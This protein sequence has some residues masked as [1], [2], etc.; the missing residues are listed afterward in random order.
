MILSATGSGTNKALNVLAGGIDVDA[1]GVSID[2]GGLSIKGS[3]T[4]YTIF[5]G[6]SNGSNITYTLPGTAPT[7]LQILRATSAD[8]TVLE[9]TN[10]AGLLPNSSNDATLRYDSGSSTWLANTNVLS[11][12][13]G[14][15]TLKKTTNQ[16]VLGTTNTTTISAPA[17]S[18]SRTYSIPDAGANASFVMT[19]GTQTIGGDKTLSGMTAINSGANAAAEL[20]FYEP[21]SDG[22]FYTSFKAGGQSANIA[23]T[24]PTTAPTAGQALV[25]DVSGNL[26]WSSVASSGSGVSFDVTAAQAA[27]LGKYVFNLE[28]SGAGTGIAYGGRIS[29]I[30]KGNNSATGLTIS[31]DAAS[32]SNIATGLSIN[33]T[34][35]SAATINYGVNV[36]AGS[37]GA[38]AATGFKAAITGGATTNIG[39]ET[40]ASGGTTSYSAKFGPGSVLIAN[41]GTN[42]TEI[43]FQEPSGSN[44]SAFK[45]QSQT[46]DVTYTLPADAGTNGQMLTTNGSGTL[47]WTSPSG[48][49]ASG[50]TTN[51]TLRYNGSGWVE[52]V[53]VLS[54]SVGA[55]TLTKTTNQL[56]LGTGS[57]TTTLNSVAPAAARTYTIPDAGANAAFVMTAGAQTIADAKTFSTAPILSSLTASKPLKLDGSK[58]VSSGAIDLATAADEVTGT[59]PVANG[60][61]GLASYST[62][63]LVYASTTN[64]LAALATGTNGKVLT[65]SSGVPAWTTLSNQLPTGTTTNAT[66]RYNGSNWVQN[67]NLLAASDGAITITK[68]SNQIVLGS[69]STITISA[70]S[71]LVNRTYTIPDASSN[72][73]FVMTA[74]DQT[75]AGTKTFSTAPN[76]NSLTASKPLKLDGSKNITSGAINLATAGGEVTG[77]LPVANGGTGLTSYA[78]GDLVYASTTNTLAALAKGTDGQYLTLT[79]G[80]PAWGTLSNQLP[81][82]TTT[83][84]TLRYNGS[85]WVQNANV[86]SN[87]DGAL[88]LAK[89][90]NQLT[91]GSSNTVTINAVAPSSSR[92]YSIPDAGANAAFVMTAG[93]QTIAGNK[94]FSGTIGG[95]RKIT[96]V[97]SDGTLSVSDGVVIATGG[98]DMTL[99]LPAVAGDSGVMLAIINGLDAGFTVSVTTPASNL[100]WYNLGTPAWENGPY[101]I[102][103]GEA[104]SLICDGTYWYILSGNL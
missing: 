66:L 79:G 15:L 45:A 74:G 82:G 61:T 24:L 6:G 31:V 40:S 38:G 75:I 72:A 64:T 4:G 5:Q 62:G 51:S 3:S 89:T 95:K 68:G 35:S 41:D 78:S 83:D 96:A 76:L 54:A 21:L 58:N 36:T 99:T 43:R 19:A 73:S 7:G 16:L 91:L 84:A 37:T 49:V 53:N 26:S 67:V 28:H 56:V 47:S 85:S 1:G 93:D 44:Y 70:A 2:A 92:T 33:S 59:L 20:R 10:A 27:T 32:N 25:S 48:G 90:T 98:A 80:L 30:A 22:T 11:N 77:T 97:N 69:A 57:F 94:T 86:L 23:Y 63:N 102:L 9:W 13:D 87:S 55:L 14:S 8:P 81:A 42:A 46:V 71:P 12:S 18:A 17:P 103:T 34:S 29:S 50:T 52:N 88:T 100:R 65:L 39:I 101:T 60:G 104:I